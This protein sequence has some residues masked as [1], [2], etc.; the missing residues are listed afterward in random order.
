MEQSPRDVPFNRLQALDE[1]INRRE[2]GNPLHDAV[3]QAVDATEALPPHEQ[4][5]ELIHIHNRAYEMEYRLR[6]GVQSSILDRA[7]HVPGVAA[8]TPLKLE[9]HLMQLEALL[10]DVAILRQYYYSPSD[11]EQRMPET[12]T[13]LHQHGNAALDIMRHRPYRR[14]PGKTKCKVVMR[15]VPLGYRSEE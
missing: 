2:L 9:L 10:Q 1:L 8:N 7:M 15:M 3:W 5:D 12:V 4:L 14:H 11:L 6:A 13:E